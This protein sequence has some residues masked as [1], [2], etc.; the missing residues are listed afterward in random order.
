MNP[1]YAARITE[2]RQA[3]ITELRTKRGTDEKQATIY[4][5][6][7]PVEVRDFQQLIQNLKKYA[8]PAAPKENRRQML[9]L[10]MSVL[11]D[12]KKFAQGDSSRGQALERSL[13]RLLAE[14]LSQN[15][16]FPHQSG[17]RGILNHVQTLQK[18]VKAQLQGKLARLTELRSNRAT[19]SKTQKTASHSLTTL[20]YFDDT[21][22]TW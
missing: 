12:G 1:K 11:E 8:L 9:A 13:Q 2:L 6:P 5:G 10:G 21:D 17:V 7:S 15:E 16:G 3:R 4:P 20:V 19:E 18:L 14:L 22:W